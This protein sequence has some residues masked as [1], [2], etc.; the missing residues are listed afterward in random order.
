MSL[1]AA[2][3]AVKQS[4]SKQK[5]LFNEIYL[6]NRRLLRAKN[7]PALAGGARESALAMTLGRNSLPSIDSVIFLGQESRNVT[8]DEIGVMLAG[9]LPEEYHGVYA[10]QAI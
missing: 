10:G 6:L 4:P 5:L 1:R 7:T 3:V 8:H 9:L 2:F